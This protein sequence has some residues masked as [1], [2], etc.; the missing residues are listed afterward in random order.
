[1]SRTINQEIILNSSPNKIYDVLTDSTQFSKFT[2]ANAE[3]DLKPGGLISLFDGMIT[4]VTIEAIQNTR[5]IQ[6]WRAG[7]WSEGNYSLVMFELDGDDVKT[8][9][10]FEQSGFPEDTKEHL[11]SG[12]H[13]MYWDP[14]KSYID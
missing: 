12:W 6:V 7:N 4:G 8:T 9:I 1:M 2:G 11:E 5:L 13:K 14:L 10:N 3:I